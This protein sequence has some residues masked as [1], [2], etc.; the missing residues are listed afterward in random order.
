MPKIINNIKDEYLK[1]A[2]RIIL[3]DGFQALTLRKVAKESNTALG[4]LYNHFDNKADLVANVMVAD[5]QKY[6]EETKKKCESI[7]DQKKG[8][9]IIYQMIRDFSNDYRSVWK[10]NNSISSITYQRHVMLVE[11]TKKLLDLVIE[12]RDDRLKRFIS[13][14]IINYGIREMDEYQDIEDYLMKIIK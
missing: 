1:I 8:L 10:E 12:N 2:K 6:L 14:I 3:V 13:E 11:Q 7:K 5:W 9:S 4:T